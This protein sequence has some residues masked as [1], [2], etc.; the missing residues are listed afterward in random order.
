MNYE[1]ACE[2]HDIIEATK[3][4][5]RLDLYRAAARYAALRTSWHLVSPDERREM[6]ARRTT[7]HNALID[8]LN[9]LTRNLTKAGE[10]TAWRRR[11]GDDRKQIGDFAVFLSARFA[12]LAR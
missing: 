5:L 3:H 6:D 10:D 12:I 11:I 7:A 1:T 9:V 2:I 4:E 8:A